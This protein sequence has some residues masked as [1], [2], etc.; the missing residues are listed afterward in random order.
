MFRGAKVTRN[1]FYKAAHDVQRVAASVASMLM[2][3]D[4]VGARCVRS[5]ERRRKVAYECKRGRPHFNAGF[6]HDAHDLR[7]GWALHR[8]ER[9]EIDGEQRLI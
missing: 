7:R 9:G 8:V 4:H 6:G 5:C 3:R 2:C 1:N